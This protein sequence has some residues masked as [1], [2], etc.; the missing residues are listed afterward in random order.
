MGTELWEA[1][2]LSLAGGATCW[3]ALGALAL[4]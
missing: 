2:D 3:V 4:R 1:G